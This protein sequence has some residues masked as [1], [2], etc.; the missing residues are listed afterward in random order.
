M[1]YRE[2][3]DTGIKASVIGIGTYPMGGWNWGGTIASKAIEAVH[4]ALDSGINWIDTAPVYGMGLSEE[5]IGKAIKGRRDKVILATKCGLIWYKSHGTPYLQQRSMPVYR[6]LSAD[7]IV[8]ELE[9]SLRRLNT[10]YIDLFQVHLP[11]ENTPVEETMSCL[12]ELQQKGKIKAIGLGNMNL[13]TLEEYLYW[14]YAA[15]FQVKYSMLDRDIEP[16]LL[17]CCKDYELSMI[18]YSPLSKG[19]LSGKVLPDKKYASDDE[20]SQNPRFT[21]NNRMKVNSLLEKLGTIAAGLGI[22]L[23]Q[24][25]LAWTVA[26]PGITHVLAGTQRAAQAIENAAAGDIQLA[27]SDLNVIRKELSHFEL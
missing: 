19:L 16:E 3:G 2:I 14:G 7:S 20:R 1:Q 8:Y 4:A 6:C 13:E 9:Q 22:T 15:S 21:P 5:I 26:Q 27:A 17:S 10:D 24:L 18:A 12:L 25:V 23:P 11:D